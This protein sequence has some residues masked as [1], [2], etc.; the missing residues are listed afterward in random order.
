MVD[1]WGKKK[2]NPKWKLCLVYLLSVNPTAIYLT[3]RKQSYNA[4][5]LIFS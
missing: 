2:K 5:L 4:Y 3:K 1:G